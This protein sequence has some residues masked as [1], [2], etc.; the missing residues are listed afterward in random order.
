MDS[1]PRAGNPVDR[2]N[3]SVVLKS[4][5]FAITA[6]F[7]I[8]TANDFKASIVRSF[9]DAPLTISANSAVCTGLKKGTP[10]NWV[11]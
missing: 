1:N 10:A 2:H 5:S 9:V 6:G 11:L 7:E 8:L 4:E 3:E